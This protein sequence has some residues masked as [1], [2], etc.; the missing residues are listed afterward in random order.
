[1][2][3]RIKEKAGLSDSG[4]LYTFKIT[5]RYYTGYQYEASDGERYPVLLEDIDIIE[6][7]EEEK[8]VPLLI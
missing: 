3:A 7:T 2:V 4:M 8:N 1:M 6:I 5:G